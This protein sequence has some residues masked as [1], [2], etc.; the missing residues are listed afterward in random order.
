MVG[1]VQHFIYITISYL[2]YTKPMTLLKYTVLFCNTHAV[3][4]VVKFKWRLWIYWAVVNIPAGGNKNKLGGQ[5]RHN[6]G[7]L[8]QAIILHCK[9][10][11]G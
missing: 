9:A 11:M 8:F 1:T 4:N 5:P 2:Y 7:M 6:S 10:T 3:P